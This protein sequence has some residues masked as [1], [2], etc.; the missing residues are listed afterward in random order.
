M[1]DF[2]NRSFVDSILVFSVTTAHQLR[3]WSPRYEQEATENSLLENNNISNTEVF[4]RVLPLGTLTKCDEVFISPEVTNKTLAQIPSSENV[5]RL[6]WVF[7]SESVLVS[8][9]LYLH[10]HC[11]ERGDCSG[12]LPRQYT[13]LRNRV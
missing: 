12:M 9:F 3:H 5:L 8:T 10:R 7:R 2:G 6:G 4:A 11:E 1:C 13:F